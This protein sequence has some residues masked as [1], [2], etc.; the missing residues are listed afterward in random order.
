MKFPPHVL[1]SAI[2]LSSLSHAQSTNEDGK[3]DKDTYWINQDS[4]D[5]FIMMNSALSTASPKL[6]S[7]D[8]LMHSMDGD[9]EIERDKKEQYWINQDIKKNP[10]TDITDSLES[11]HTTP[12]I[13]TQE[14]FYTGFGAL[15]DEVKQQIQ[16]S[17]EDSNSNATLK[18][19]FALLAKHLIERIILTHQ[20]HSLMYSA[21]VMANPTFVDYAYA[22]IPSHHPAYQDYNQKALLYGNQ[23]QRIQE[24]AFHRPLKQVTEPQQRHRYSMGMTDEDLTHFF[25][26]H[27][28]IWGNNI[29]HPII[30]GTRS[31][32]DPKDGLSKEQKLD[33]VISIINKRFNQRQ[34][35]DLMLVFAD[36]LGHLNPDSR[37][38]GNINP[39]AFSVSLTS[40]VLFS[41][42]NP[43]YSIDTS[44][45]NS[46][47]PVSINH[48]TEEPANDSIQPADF[49]EPLSDDINNRSPQYHE[50]LE[51]GYYQRADRFIPQKAM[52][53]QAFAQFYTEAYAYNDSTKTTKAAWEL[54]LS[55]LKA[56]AQDKGYNL[57]LIPLQLT[58]QGLAKEDPFLQRDI[59]YQDLIAYEGEDPYLI[60][61]IEL[62]DILTHPDTQLNEID[63][64]LA[65]F[66]NA[67]AWDNQESEGLNEE[68]L[69]RMP[70]SDNAT[71]EGRINH[72]PIYDVH[73]DDLMFSE[74]GY[75][76][77]SQTPHATRNPFKFVDNRVNILGN[78]SLESQPEEQQ[79]S[80]INP[81]PPAYMDEDLLDLKKGNL[82]LEG[83]LEKYF[84]DFWMNIKRQMD[85]QE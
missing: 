36:Y 80:R 81:K 25:E 62:V 1:A 79:I 53:H 30:Q 20:S 47:I 12:V 33:F 76:I 49:R 66:F 58:T 10:N 11:A 46:Q 39:K 48:T 75:Q 42:V 16:S 21:F 83:F 51:Y 60:H 18:R 69:D 77:N 32:Y 7:Q 26:E 15:S 59:I 14:I 68:V 82:D 27:P 85:L 8:V 73:A 24:H 84:P 40:A 71:M 63:Q 34:P 2:L 78:Q 28:Q 17:W 56:Y 22:L 19:E 45:E 6:Q 9:D 38:I 52:Y 57:D 64:S 44:N 37:A 55:V 61:F 41:M 43:K 31:I 3:N 72:P 5:S 50:N 35:L 23:D 13:S 67:L 70:L 65:H 54:T 74:T 29:L 4:S